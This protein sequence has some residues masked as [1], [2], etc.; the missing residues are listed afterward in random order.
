MTTSRPPSAKTVPAE[1]THHGDTVADE[2]AWPPEK[3]DPDTLA[4]LRAE[5]EYTEAATAHLAGLWETVFTETKPRTQETEPA[6]FP[7]V[8]EVWLHLLEERGV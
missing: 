4:Y 6:A 2:Y 5:N 8:S 7:T 1:R 3:D